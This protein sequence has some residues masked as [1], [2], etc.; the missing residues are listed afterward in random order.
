[1]FVKEDVVQVWKDLGELVFPGQFYL[2]VQ[3]F[4]RFVEENAGQVWEDGGKSRSIDRI[5]LTCFVTLYLL[6]NC[7]YWPV[8]LLH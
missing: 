5:M 6:F 1:M 3:L 7:I 4:H 8:C 2:N